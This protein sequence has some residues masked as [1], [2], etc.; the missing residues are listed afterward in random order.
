[1]EFDALDA[2]LALAGA[3]AGAAECHG[4]LTGW[5]ASGRGADPQQWLEPMLEELDPDA[6]LVVRCRTDLVELHRAVASQL[7]GGALDFMLLLPEDDRPLTTRVAALAEW[8]AGFL[9]GLGLAGEA[10]TRGGEE[11]REVIGDFT[12]IGRAGLETGDD[13]E[14]DEVA[15]AELV[16]YVRIGAHLV[17]D[18]LRGDPPRRLH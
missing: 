15:Y 17:H 16:E 10:A 8:C 11:V 7:R 12:E 9:F 14:Q 6:A 2:S 13:T 18:T 5:L 1:M 4:A 3:H